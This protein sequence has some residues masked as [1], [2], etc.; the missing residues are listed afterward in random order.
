M[1]IPSDVPNDPVQQDALRAQFEEHYAKLLAFV[2]WRSSAA[3]AA[4]RDPEELLHD[5]YLRAHQRWRSFEKSG[6]AFRPWFFRVIRDTLF[7]DHDFQGCLKRDYRREKA[8]P[9]RSS[10]QFEMGIQSPATTASMALARKEE[11][12]QKREK[13]RERIDQVLALLTPIQQEIMVLIHFSGLKKT[14]A[15]AIL[16]IK[17]EA[18]R[19]RYGDAIPRFRE[20]WIERHGEEGLG[21]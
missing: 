4:R 5:A 18:A 12:Q 15:A 17:P 10:A 20:L 6:M 13:L 2:R 3:L 16:G 9:D 21:T 19:K 1:R 7:D 8:F 14:Q 11:Q